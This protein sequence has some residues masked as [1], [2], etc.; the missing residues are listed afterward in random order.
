MDLDQEKDI[1][2][3]PAIQALV[4]VVELLLVMNVGD[5][6]NMIE[7]K[8]D[9]VEEEGGEGEVEVGEVMSHPLELLQG[10]NILNIGVK[11][12][13]MTKE[14]KEGLQAITVE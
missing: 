9:T 1:L 14:E 5:S 13:D 6:K 4:E 3:A 10:R 2:Q 7:V 12:E 11:G 8:E